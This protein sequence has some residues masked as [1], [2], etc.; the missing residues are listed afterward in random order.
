M[1]VSEQSQEKSEQ[2]VSC[3]LEKLSIEENVTD[4]SQ[5]DLEFN[6]NGRLNSGLDSRQREV[7]SMKETKNIVEEVGYLKQ[8][9]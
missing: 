5:G 4:K 2:E 7:A 9:W 6:C 8:L 1:V 3:K